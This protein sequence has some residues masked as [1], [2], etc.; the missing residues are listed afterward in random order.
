MPNINN[1]K[2][3]RDKL[4]ELAATGHEELFNYSLWYDYDLW[5]D[6]EIPEP[7]AEER[8]AARS[9]K[10]LGHCGTCGCVAGWTCQLLLPMEH[11]PISIRDS[12]MSLLELSIEDS[13]FLFHGYEGYGLRSISECLE[14]ATIGDAIDRLNALITHYES[15]QYSNYWEARNDCS[16]DDQY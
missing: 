12:A 10:Y 6:I 13:G 3:V 1:L 5:P 7:T 4:L 16:S 2:I 15:E 14:E 8:E 11:P 9:I